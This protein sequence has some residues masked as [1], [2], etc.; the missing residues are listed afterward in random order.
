M[1]VP[2]VSDIHFKCVAFLVIRQYEMSDY[3][4]IELQCRNKILSFIQKKK[5]LQYEELI[6]F[7]LDPIMLETN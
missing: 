2:L 5:I 6:N 4:T 7:M 1:E 3:S